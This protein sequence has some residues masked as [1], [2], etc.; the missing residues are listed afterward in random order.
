MS[1]VLINLKT[2]TILLNLNSFARDKSSLV[3]CHLYR[4][5]WR[6][7]PFYRYRVRQQFLQIALLRF[8]HCS[9]VVEGLILP[10]TLA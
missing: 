8:L 10:T 1:K 2:L 6:R 7:S 9:M 5:I 3:L 4:V